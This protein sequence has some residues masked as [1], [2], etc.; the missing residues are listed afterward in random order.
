MADIK[1]AITLNNSQ[2]QSAINQSTS[3]VAGLGTK[4]AATGATGVEAFN[5]LAAGAEIVSSKMNSM[6]GA[7]VGA[8]LLTFAH[9]AAE[10]VS[11][12]VDLGKSVGVSTQAMMEMNLAAVAAGSSGEEVAKM[13]QKMNIA[14]LDAANGNT[15]LQSGMEELGVTQD[16]LRTHSPEEAFKK[17][18]AALGEITDV[19]KR[20]TLS[21][22]IFGKTGNKQVWQDLS[23]GMNKYSGT[24][25]EAAAAT[26]S[27]KK[28]M[29]EL[30]VGTENV[31]NQFILLL[32]PVTS[33]A[34]PMID[35]LGGAKA[36]AIG[37]AGAMTL[38][39]GASVITAV[40]TVVSGVAALATAMTGSTIATAANTAVT[41]ANSR[42]VDTFMSGA[43][44]RLGRAT[45]TAAVA[46][47][48]LS[49]LQVTGTATALS[50]AAAE[51][52][53][54]AAQ[55]RV[56]IAQ[57]AQTLTA[58]A[59]TAAMATQTAAATVS[60]EASLLTTTAVGGLS[61]RLLALVP[62]AAM[63][64]VA[65]LGVWP[66]DLNEG[67]DALVAKMKEMN[68]LMQ[69]QQALD[70]K[71]LD[72]YYKLSP[73]AQEA[74]QKQLVL[75]KQ[76]NVESQA[77]SVL[78]PAK[79]TTVDSS[80]LDA[81]KAQGESLRLN[82]TLAKEKLE[83]DV[84]SL[85][86]TETQAQAATNRLEAESTIRQNNLKAQQEIAKLEEQA[87]NLRGTDNI[88]AD[89]LIAQTGEIKKQLALNN[90]QVIALEKQKNAVNDAK[91]AEKDRILI[92][93]LGLKINQEEL[94]LKTQIGL[95]G[96]TNEQKALA[97]IQ[98]RIDAE[99]QG[100][101][102]IA[103]ARNGNRPITQEAEQK[104]KETVTP[105]YDQEKELAVSLQKANDAEAL[106]VAYMTIEEKIATN[107][108][109]MQRDDDELTMTNDQIK[110][111]NINRRIDA[112]VEGIV[113]IRQ[114]QQ[115][116]KPLS[117]DEVASIRAELEPKFA[118]EKLATQSLIAKS[119]EFATGFKKNWNDYA[120]QATN[121]AERGKAVFS[122]MQTAA[123]TAMDKILGDSDE[124]WTKIFDNAV[125]AMIKSDM[126]NML[127]NLMNSASGG[128]SGGFF[129]SL[130]KMFAGGFA[131]GG[132]IPAGSYGITGENGP[133]VV[134]GPATITPMTSG[135]TYHVT[136]NA[137]DAKS[138]VQMMSEHP[139]VIYGLNLK[140]A[141]SLGV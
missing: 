90:E 2:F 139:E 114:A 61:A 118:A 134:N 111:N 20:A 52:K 97:D 140:G 23:E 55:F 86:M 65:L 110:L 29:D 56:S 11:Q 73:E 64:A 54:A 39:A 31:K 3:S 116:N 35:G 58:A 76:M 70:P 51:E 85:S 4:L 78:S 42:A 137:N 109:T 132:N 123:E 98:K 30:A 141:R 93:E 127:G 82:N 122:A 27:A 121:A 28:V 1:S 105:K 62:V 94:D 47:A 107:I 6:G 84:K 34:A 138:F 102:K 126:K 79:K 10:S 113:K 104:I 37:L 45:A 19:S 43:Y 117:E 53:L 71:F 119:R 106:R 87:A 33:F 92:Q 57:E 89:Q 60:T 96:A 130:G 44:A 36:A 13:I 128:S 131:T 50:L 7:I 67:E 41:I 22:D 17:M 135:D 108:Q 40:R 25:K 95:V 77:Q 63:A 38:F 32:E 24:Q 49:A 91:T 80:A 101:I 48:E 99:V 100:E 8:G 18:S 75:Q 9:A 26:E 81:I 15:K 69:E 112:E 59:S 136:I 133:E 14:A 12:M 68:K 115:G 129:Q 21:M 125:K 74:L 83:L 66:K 72:N 88:K 120:D 5:K 103:M 124:T 16:Y 46:Q